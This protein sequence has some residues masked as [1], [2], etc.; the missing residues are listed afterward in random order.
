[1]KYTEAKQGRVFIVR[2]EHGDIIH[3]TVERFAKEKNILSAA[4]IIV[5]GADKGSNLV[6]GPAKGDSSP[7]NAMQ[8]TLDNVY[9]VTG[10]GT[11]FP[12]ENGEPMLH[13]HIA[14]GRNTSTITGCIRKGVKTWNLLEIIIFEITDTKSYRKFNESFGFHLLEPK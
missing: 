2:L 11:I 14:C 6:V 9:E 12:D 1:M 4:L 8:L 7:I 3:E 5:G 10:S 13:L